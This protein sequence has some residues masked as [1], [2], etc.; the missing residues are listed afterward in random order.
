MSA[1]ERLQEWTTLELD[2]IIQEQIYEEREGD[3]IRETAAEHQRRE[4][5]TSLPQGRQEG[6]GRAYAYGQ[7]KLMAFQ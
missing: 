2:R 6:N 1:R 5:N 4:N 7:K 3:W